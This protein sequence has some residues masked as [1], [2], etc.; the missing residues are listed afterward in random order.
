MKI[1]AGNLFPQIVSSINPDM[2]SLTEIS[3][4]SNTTLTSATVEV[5][6]ADKDVSS[7]EMSLSEGMQ[8]VMDQLIGKILAGGALGEGTADY[9]KDVLGNQMLR[10]GMGKILK[11]DNTY[12]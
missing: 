11:T 7:K 10:K 12:F 9:V 3:S 6:L 5:E 2:A 4:E 1:K 8:T